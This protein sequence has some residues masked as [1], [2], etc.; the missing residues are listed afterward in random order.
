MQTQKYVKINVNVILEKEMYVRNRNYSTKN[1]PN[2]L[3]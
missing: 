1:Q 3:Y 2:D